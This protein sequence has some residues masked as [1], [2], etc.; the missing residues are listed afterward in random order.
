M[1]ADLRDD[2]D[3]VVV[4]TGAGGATAARVLS[5]AGHSVVMLEEGPEIAPADRKKDLLG[6]MRDTF[7]EMGTTI[8]KAPLP[9]PV[10]QGRLVG[11]TTAINSGIIW[12][13]PEAIR[14][15]WRARFG[16]GDLVDDKAL[17]GAFD[18]IEDELGIG[19]TPRQIMGRNSEVL[20]VGAR[21]LGYEGHLTLR[22]TPGCE[23]TNLCLQGCRGSKRQGMDVSYVPRSIASGA[24]LHPLARVRRVVIQ[25]GRAVSVVGE[26][27]DR[28]TRRPVG[29]LEVRARRGVIV[30]GGVVQTAVILR[31]S[32]LRG[33]V[34]ERFQAHPGSAIVGRFEE[35]INMAFGATQGYQVPL[36]DR[37]Y[38]IESLSL[39]PEVL[40]VRLPGAGAQWQERISRMNHY[41]QWAVMVR[42]LAHGRVRPGFGRMADVRYSPGLDDLE[43]LR[44]GFALAARM[45]FAAGAIEVYPGIGGRP[46][47]LRD[48]SEVKRIEEGPIGRR[49]FHLLATHLFGTACAGSDPRRSVVSPTL[50]S[51]DV[52]DLFVMDA[53]VFPTNIGVNPQ[54]SIM[55]VVWRAAEQLANRSARPVAA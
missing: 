23:G 33:L 54:H 37:G 18:R 40:A 11:G 19:V 14:E 22:N 34:G 20:E 8:A 43:K 55:G 26:V 38:K 29:T 51:H 7:R 30:S 16:L 42:M 12:R 10:L 24:R 15:D 36:F 27:V 28:E 1:S 4:G 9:F 50:E 2:A 45:M 47:I 21:A 6:A 41:A 3:F 53:S 46:E 44:H 25:G 39:P 31:R 13:M 52:Q 35:P 32:G 49:D 17:D 5:G 48:V